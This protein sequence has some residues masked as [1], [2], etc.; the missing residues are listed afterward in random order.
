MERHH[1]NSLHATCVHNATRLLSITRE[2]PVA[3]VS[4]TPVVYLLFCSPF[5]LLLRFFLHSRKACTASLA[6]PTSARDT[7]PREQHW[8]GRPLLT[9]Q[10]LRGT[11]KL[12]YCSSLSFPL[13]CQAS[14]SGLWTHIL[15][16][17]LVCVY[18]EPA[19]IIGKSKF[20]TNKL[21]AL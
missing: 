15:L 3:P 19:Q 14:L 4:L 12:S 20:Q 1:P 9:Q 10:H 6:L 17:I 11:R 16:S 7:G 21:P 13:W 8:E 5:C 18:Y 2:T